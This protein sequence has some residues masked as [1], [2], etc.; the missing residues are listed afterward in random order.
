MVVPVAVVCVRTKSDIA[1]TRNRPRLAVALAPGRCESHERVFEPSA[2]AGF[3]DQMFVV[4][5]EG[6]PAG[7]P[8]VLQAVG[9]QLG[10][11]HLQV[12]QAVLGQ[13]NPAGVVGSERPR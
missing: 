3:A 2:V 10:G 12:I 4:P 9:G 11:D 7:A 8:G 6:Q 13:S 1:L 5:P